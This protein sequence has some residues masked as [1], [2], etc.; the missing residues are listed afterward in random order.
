MRFAI[1]ADIHANR[2]A[3]EACLA[4]LAGQRIDRIIY[5]GDMLGYGA[6]PH[7]VLDQIRDHIAR[8]MAEALLGNHEE[9]VLSAKASGM[10]PVAE[11]AI[12][13]QRGRLGADERAFIAALPM[14][15]DTE[16]VCFVHADPAAPK[17]WTYVTDIEAATQSLKGSPAMLAICGHVHRPALYG[18]QAAGRVISFRPPANEAVP[19]L[20]AR[21]WL[22]VMG[23]VGQP[24][25]GNAAACYGILDTAA[26]ECSWQRVA[27]DVEG[28]AAAIRAA[29]L[30][31]T[32]AA[33]LLRGE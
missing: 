2:Q 13:W 19:L 23:A 4:H 8:G 31:D 21:R 26:A 27:Y 33:R 24:R 1:L 15:I 11:A 20:R 5:L 6:D 9:A 18:V 7:W 12:A 30:P 22:A 14:V 28:A 16:G 17:R 10:N 25:D 3:L 29:G 32:L